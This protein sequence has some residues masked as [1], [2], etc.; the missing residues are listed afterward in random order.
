MKVIHFIFALESRRMENCICMYEAQFFFNLILATARNI[1]NLFFGN[2]L[3]S[4]IDFPV[5]Q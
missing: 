1:N 4:K 2:L 3:F 5:T